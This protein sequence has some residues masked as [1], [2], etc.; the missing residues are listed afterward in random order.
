[1]S[2]VVVSDAEEDYVEEDDNVSV[3]DG[4]NVSGEGS[5]EGEEGEEDEEDEEGEETYESDDDDSMMLC[6]ACS[7]KRQKTEDEK[8]RRIAKLEE[9]NSKLRKQNDEIKNTM[10]PKMLEVR[11]TTGMLIKAFSAYSGV[12]MT[13]S[14]GDSSDASGSIQSVKLKQVFN[15]GDGAVSCEQVDDIDAPVRFSATGSFPHAIDTNVR[16]QSRE[17]QLEAR[18]KLT[19]KYVLVSK[20]DDRKVNE[21]WIRADGCVPFKISVQYAD[22]RDE[23]YK[24]DFQ[25]V[26]L[27]DMTDPKF[28]LI[29]TQK[30]LNGELSFN[31]QVRFTSCDTTPKHRQFIFKV[32]PDIEG[33][34]DNPDL[35]IFT[36]PF[37][38]RSKVTAQK[39]YK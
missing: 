29:N 37:S 12:S 8:D 24:S 6:P 36:P 33:L 23:V 27:N 31:F 35:T 14:G 3:P 19:L 39:K 34:V 1:M 2:D 26:A 28:D 17:F 18:R 22:N 25:R 7:S 4:D 11:E 30:M 10:M 16:T 20:L 15:I 21:K 13:S 32:T 5:E 9:E 38:V